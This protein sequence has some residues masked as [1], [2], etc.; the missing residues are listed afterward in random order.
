VFCLPSGWCCQRAR[1]ETQ[2][3]RELGYCPSGGNPAT[4]KKYAERWGISAEHF[5]PTPV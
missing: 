5:D 2:V 4:V 1:T 3:L